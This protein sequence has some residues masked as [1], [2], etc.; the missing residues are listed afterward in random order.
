MDNRNE[1]NKMNSLIYTRKGNTKTS[2]RLPEGV[3]RRRARNKGDKNG[4]QK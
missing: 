2:Q 1:D 4:K 3:D